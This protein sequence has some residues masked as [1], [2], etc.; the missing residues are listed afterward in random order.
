[1]VFLGGGSCRVFEVNGEWIFRFSHAPE[2][3]KNLIREQKLLKS[4]PQFKELSIPRYDYF[5]TSA[6][7]FPHPFGGYRKINGKTLEEL[8]LPEDTLML[9]AEQL[10]I[11]LRQLHNVCLPLLAIPEEEAKKAKKRQIVDFLDRIRNIAFPLLEKNQKR[12]TEKCFEE[13][14]TD[15]D[16]FDFRPVTVHGD[17]DSSNVIIDNGKVRG[18]IDFEEM[19]FTDPAVDFCVFLAEFGEAFVN[20]MLEAYVSCNDRMKRS[21]I[22]HSRMIIFIE[23]LYGIEQRESRHLVNALKRLELAMNGIK[24]T[25]SWLKVSTSSTRKIPGYP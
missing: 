7:G 1:M 3:D 8:T 12:W 24:K 14:L 17:L 2:V 13:F 5:L 4:L 10:G 25:G 19:G 18:I 9:I 20:R 15:E 23:L 6:G 11:F 16:N 21:I 22:F